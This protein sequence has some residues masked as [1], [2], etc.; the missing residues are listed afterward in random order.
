VQFGYGLDVEQAIIVDVEAAP[1]RAFDEVVATRT[2]IERTVRR[3]D[4]KP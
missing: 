1:A 4:L 3:L 2:M